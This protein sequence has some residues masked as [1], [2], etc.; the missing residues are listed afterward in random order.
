MRILQH[1]QRRKIAIKLFALLFFCT[2]YIHQKWFDSQTPVSRLNVLHS[3]FV[4]GTLAINAYHTNTTDK[5]RVA[6]R[7]YSD[8]APGTVVL[9]FLPFAVSACILGIS[10]VDLDSGWLFSSWIACAGSISIV[11]ALG[12]AMMFGF[13]CKYV[14]PIFALVSTLALF[15]GSA[16]L[17]YATMMFSHALVVGLIAIGI[18]AVDRGGKIVERGEGVDNRNAYFC[19][20]RWDFT[21]G[22]ACGWALA[23]EYSAGLSVGGIVIWLISVNWRR[24]I[25]F[26]MAALLPMLLI[27][28]YSWLSVGDPFTLPYDHQASFPEMQEGLYAIRLPDAEIAWN[29]LFSPA[30]GLLF[31]SPF[32]AMAAF[33]YA[34]LLLQSK[35]LFWLS[36]TIPLVHIVVISGRAWDWPAGPTLGPR[37][38]AHI[39][40]WLALPCAY[41]IERFKRVGVVLVGYSILLTMAATLTNAC[42][43]FSRHPNPI[44]DLHLPMI[45]SGEFSPNLGSAFG[46][47]AYMSVFLYVAVAIGGVVSEVRS[48]V[49]GWPTETS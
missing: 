5:A 42:P 49:K 14:N 18:W 9:A 6:D 19:R 37:L 25:P 21:A 22:C 13:L 2:T 15:L 35:R 43:S 23:S 17:P 10:N 12:G 7:Y 27:P 28:F 38:L 40:P 8:K 48:E 26:A 45:T 32:L 36:L 16:P 30:R 34:R 39:L 47:P 41:G 20:H 33:G 31:W 11:T 46:L 44:M 1:E 24:V 29:L 4:H 3:V